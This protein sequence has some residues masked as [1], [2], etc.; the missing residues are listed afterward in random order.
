MN[1]LK[2]S[3]WVR[4]ALGATWIIDGLLQLQPYMFT[5]S[6]ALET[7]ASTASNQPFI[8][9]DPIQYVAKTIAPHIVI[10][11][12]LFALIQLGIGIGIL[13]PRLTKIA[14][15][16]SFLWVLGVWWFGEGLGQIISG[17]STLLSGAPGAVVI[18]GL[19]GLLVWPT[20]KQK[21]ESVAS[22]SPTGV[23]GGKI[24]WASLWC[25]DG[26]LQLLPS[27]LSKNA[28]SGV[29]SSASSGEPYLI[30]HVNNF[31]AN[32]MS[33]HGMPI[34]LVLGILQ[35][36]VGIGVFAKS[37]NT[38]LYF[39]SLLSL[40]FWVIAQDFGGILTGQGTDPNSG[41]LLVILALAIYNMNAVPRFFFHARSL[42]RNKI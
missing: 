29:F 34:G 14:L 19:I 1:T 39:G 6:F 5:K 12:T 37:Y 11:N 4:N 38:A 21:G 9:S 23:V 16:V 20:N 7:L 31:F 40:F 22:I 41:P 24:I 28:L 33:G 42:R 3:K 36:A 26:V 15:A 8:I 27:N 10:W 35:I 30:A 13:V 32:L 18:Y 17:G 25:V 2:A